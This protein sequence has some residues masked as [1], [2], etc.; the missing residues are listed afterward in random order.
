LRLQSIALPADRLDG[1]DGNSKLVAQ[2]GHDCV[3]MSSAAG[4]DAAAR[5][6]GEKP[7]SEGNGFD[8]EGRQRSRSIPDRKAFDGTNVEVVPVE[9][10][11]A[12]TAEIR[13]VEQALE[14]P[15]VDPAGSARS[16]VTVERNAGPGQHPIVQQRVARAGIESH[17]VAFSADPGKVADTAEIEDEHRLAQTGAQG[18]MV[19]RQ[20][21]RSLPALGNIGRAEIVHDIDP[22]FGSKNGPVADLPSA[23]LMWR[24]QDRL[25]VKADQVHFT[26]RQSSVLEQPV[27]RVSV[28]PGQLSLDRTNVAA[29]S[30]S[31]AQ[32]VAKLRRIRQSE[33]R[34]GLNLLIAIGSDE[35][36][37]N[38][39]HRGAAH[40]A[41]YGR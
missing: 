12:R 18:P 8:R 34:P 38:P 15:T 16:T 17:D 2:P 14:R 28:G 10:F 29:A 40:E 30:K 27:H 13:V 32:P 35:C 36:G 31:G 11:G 20:Q 25:A 6:L 4:H 19:E 41:D 37:I 24:V 39:V 9:R 1:V 23:P 22:G 3:V 26:G 7:D 33:E 21:R 5:R